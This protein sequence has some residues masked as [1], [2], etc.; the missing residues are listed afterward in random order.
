[1]LLIDAFRWW[2]RAARDR[3]ALDF[4]GDEVS[5]GALDR[6]S[7]GV[8]YLLSEM[9]VAKDDVV[10]IA[11]ANSLEWCAAA[12]GLLKLGA[13]IAPANVRYPPGELAHFIADTNPRLVLADAGEIPKLRAVPGQGAGLEIVPL[14]DLIALRGGDHAPVA[15]EVS[16]TAPA[17]ILYTSGT[18]GS[19]RG[20]VYTNQG[21]MN[22]MV[23]ALLMDAAPSQDTSMLLTFPL[24]T[25]AGVYIALPRML[26]RGGKLVLMREFEPRRALELIARH[27][28]N[29]VNGTPVMWERMA[30]EPD[31][32]AYDLSHLK[33]ALTGGARLAETV[34]AAFHRRG[35]A[36]RQSY[37]QTESGG[38]A[39]IARVDDA[40]SHP[41]CCGDGGVFTKV[42]VVRADG[43]RC[44]AGEA[45]EIVI[46]GPNTMQ[47]YWRNLEKTGE[48]VI[49]G[50]LRTGDLG[51]AD[52]MGRLRFLDRLSNL[53]VSGGRSLS[54]NALEAA[55]G[56]VEGVTEVAVVAVPDAE[57]GQ[58]AAAIVYA[59]SGDV[60]RSAIDDRLAQSPETADALR[61][62]VLRETPLP[63]LA[64]GKVDRKGLRDE[65]AGL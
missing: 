3:T 57:L 21:M 6:W 48:A 42:V 16:P 56:T 36:L 60:A 59:V 52:E 64:S 38:A 33:V 41:E 10:V 9:G 61:H 30:A 32:E 26:A 8:A 63:R 29:Q 22:A 43:T 23:E 46:H 45:G 49:D 15:V 65:Y 5:Y 55:I 47:G 40:L 24:F 58:G 53:I 28:I 25:S 50:W 13:I 17:M 31:F 12:L 19:P 39:T 7:D 62:L 18:T 20:I 51:V 2:V 34:L 44:D 54:P 14:D 1:M 27:R 35:V 11:G 4:D 37:G